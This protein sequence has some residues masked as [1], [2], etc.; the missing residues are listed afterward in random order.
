M[1]QRRFRDRGEVQITLA[2]FMLTKD[3]LKLLNTQQREKSKTP[4]LM[5]NQFHDRR[6]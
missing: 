3:G 2:D 6:E 5:K 4:A 1:R